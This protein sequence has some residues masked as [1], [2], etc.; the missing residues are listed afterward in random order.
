MDC[1]ELFWI[2]FDYMLLFL[3]NLQPLVTRLGLIFLKIDMYTSNLKQIPLN[4]FL[5]KNKRI[6]LVL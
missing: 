1:N 2:I 5:F 6:N 4:P 3:L